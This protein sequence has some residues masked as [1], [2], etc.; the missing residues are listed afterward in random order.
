[1]NLIILLLYSLI[2]FVKTDTLAYILTDIHTHIHRY[3]H[4]YIH[5]FR[6][7]KQ[8]QNN[9]RLRH[10]HHV[11]TGARSEFTYSYWVHFPLKP[12]TNHC[13]GSIFEILHPASCLLFCWILHLLLTHLPSPQTLCLHL[14]LLPFNSPSSLSLSFNVSLHLIHLFFYLVHLITSFL[15]FLFFSSIS[16]SLFLSMYDVHIYICVRM[17]ACV[18]V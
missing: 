14:F 16:P 15:I 2:I 13:M 4:T 17:C 8:W 10:K 7:V 3:I 1:M 11:Q 5:T 12:V 6:E 9:Q 18:C